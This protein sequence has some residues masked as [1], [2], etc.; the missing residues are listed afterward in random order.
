MSRELQRLGRRILPFLGAGILLQTGGCAV[1]F[2][3]LAAGLATSV[4]N[5]FV[6]NL[7]FGL[8]NV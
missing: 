5:S 2:S 3:T 6:S 8:F 4:A 1:D 7:V